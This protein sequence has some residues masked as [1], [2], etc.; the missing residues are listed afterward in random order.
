ME[1]GLCGADTPVRELV[2]QQTTTVNH[3]PAK[4]WRNPPISCKIDVSATGLEGF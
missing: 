2:H 1:L 3:S 4:F